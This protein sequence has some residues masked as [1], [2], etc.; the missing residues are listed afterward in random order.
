MADTS[1]TVQ[2]YLKELVLVVLFLTSAKSFV[3]YPSACKRL[4]TTDQNYMG[5]ADLTENLCNAANIFF[6]KFDIRFQLVM[7]VIAYY[8][9][10]P[11]EFR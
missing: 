10:Y 1:E 6:F 4:H 5:Q 2:N 3:I 7:F 8:K 9:R 11:F